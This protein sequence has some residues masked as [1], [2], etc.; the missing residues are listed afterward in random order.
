MPNE[1]IIEYY[2][3]NFKFYE[4][5]AHFKILIMNSRKLSLYLL[6]TP[7]PYLGYYKICIKSSFRVR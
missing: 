4:L 3:V 1:I 7:P 2:W 6:R 5:G